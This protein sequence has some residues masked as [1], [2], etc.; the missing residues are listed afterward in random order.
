ME[1]PSWSRD[2]NHEIVIE[3][4]F[5]N[6]RLAVIYTRGC[7]EVFSDIVDRGGSRQALPAEYDIT[8]PE[9]EAGEF[10][11]RTASLIREP[12]AA[13]TVTLGNP[14]AYRLCINAFVY[15]LTR[16]GTIARKLVDSSTVTVQTLRDMWQIQY[17]E[18]WRETERSGFNPGWNGK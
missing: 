16:Q 9:Y 12:Q 6:G 5:L 8:Y 18:Q 2:R 1:S 7:R 15:A 13:Q 17:R 11:P 10:S 14:K 3:G 4:I